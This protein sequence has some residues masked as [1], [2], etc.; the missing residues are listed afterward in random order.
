MTNPTI[1]VSG[2]TGSQGGSVVRHLKR[3]G[4]HRVRAL[5]RRPEAY[6]G[7][8]DEA[9]QV[10]LDVEATLEGA[11]RGAHGVFLVTNFWEQGTDEIQQAKAALRAARQA[12]VEHLIWS[13]LPNVEEISGG[14]WEVPHFTDKARVDAMVREAGFPRFTIVQPPFYFENLLGTMGP[15]PMQDGRK[16]WT[17]PIDPDARVIH[18]GAID[19]L[20]SLVAGAFARPEQSAGRTLAMSAG[21]YSFADVVEAYAAASGEDVGFARVPHEVFSD[22]FPG[23]HEISQMLGYFE[24]HTYMGPDSE[25]RLAEGRRVAMAPFTPLVEWL[26]SALSSPNPANRRY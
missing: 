25:T 12:G 23:A 5:T 1:A 19:E 24:D 4:A 16:G 18:M 26:S 9:V 3:H 14:R 21:L 11:L 22:F 10:D 8:A 20:G 7:P 17:L 13:S 15:Q 2:A 6:D